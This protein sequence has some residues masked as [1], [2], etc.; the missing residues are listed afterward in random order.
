MFGTSGVT[1]SKFDHV[2]ACNT[3]ARILVHFSLENTNIFYC[4]IYPYWAYINI[5]IYKYQ[6]LCL[7]FLFEQ[8]PVI[9]MCNNMLSALSI[10]L[11]NI[12]TISALILRHYSVQTTPDFQKLDVILHANSK[13]SWTDKRHTAQYWSEPIE[14][15]FPALIAGHSPVLLVCKYQDLFWPSEVGHAP[16]SKWAVLVVLSRRTYDFTLSSRMSTVLPPTVP[17]FDV[18]LTA[19]S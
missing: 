6:N 4:N 5:L 7:S 19:V 2:S 3:D 9:I 18:R 14:N 13:E 1:H 10:Q 16:V 17:A 12:K 11:E 8:I 15:Q